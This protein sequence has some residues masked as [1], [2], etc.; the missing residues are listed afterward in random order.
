MKPELLQQSG[1]YVSVTKVLNLQPQ[2]INSTF[3]ARPNFI[4]ASLSE[5]QGVMMSTALACVHAYIRTCTYV[6]ACRRG[7]PGK[8]R[9][10]CGWE[11][12]K[13]GIDLSSELAAADDGS[14]GSLRT[15]KNAWQRS[16]AA[17]ITEKRFG[18]E[19]FLPCACS[20]MYEGKVC[21]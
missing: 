11:R 7:L 10:D 18:P 20:Y 12:V 13:S 17:I 14:D 9:G 5:P 6:P 2:I 21:A 15:D 1:C 4:G 16:G 19:N 3:E 8:E